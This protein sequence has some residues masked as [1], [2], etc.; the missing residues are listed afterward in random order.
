[1]DTGLWSVEDKLTSQENS[2]LTKPFQE[3]EIK[4]ALFLMERNKAAWPDGIPI[5]FYQSCWDFI[6]E[7]IVQMFGDLYTGKLDVKRLNYGLITLLPKV[8][9]AIRIQQYRSIC[10]LNCIYNWITKLLTLRLEKVVGRILHQAQ[11]GFVQG[12]NIMNNVMALHEIPH[13][14]KKRGETGTVLKLDF[15]KVTKYIGAS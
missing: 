15:E 4:Q 8:K 1:L 6:R 12:R 10:L 14:T 7:D 3:D 9:H 11:T 2:E 13:E 5:E